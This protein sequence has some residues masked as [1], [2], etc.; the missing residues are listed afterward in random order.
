[1]ADQ[2]P[3][4]KQALLTA[5]AGVTAYRKDMNTEVLAMGEQEPGWAFAGA[6]ALS[7]WLA[8]EVRRLGG[9]PD[10]LLRRVY[11]AAYDLTP[12]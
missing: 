5:L 3:G 1:M 6:V 7:C 8:E 4:P 2:P 10:E 11:C 9:D 12:S